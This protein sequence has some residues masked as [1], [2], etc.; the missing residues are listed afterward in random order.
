[1]RRPLEN[2]GSVTSWPIGLSMEQGRI[3]SVLACCLPFPVGI[4][5]I[6]KTVAVAFI[7]SEIWACLAP[8]YPEIAVRYAYED[9]ICDHADEG[10]YG[11]L[12]CA[13]LQSAAFVEKDMDKLVSIA[14]SYIR[15]T[16]FE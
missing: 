10:V 13:A 12:F 9:A 4:T 16:N 3:I 5:I 14:K 8:G 11:E 1:M 15:L 7:R 2:T 6:I